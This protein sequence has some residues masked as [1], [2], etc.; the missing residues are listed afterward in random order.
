MTTL[1]KLYEAAAR[2][3]LLKTCTWLPAG[4]AVALMHPVGL[5]TE[6]QTVLDNLAATTETTMSY[7]ASCFVGLGPRERVEIDGTPFQVREVR[8]VGDGSEL[9]ARLTRL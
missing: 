3:G 7:P 1:E 6:A 4:G 2:V 8:P 9:H 5:Q